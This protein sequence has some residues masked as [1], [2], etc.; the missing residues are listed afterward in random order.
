MKRLTKSA[1]LVV[2]E[3][4]QET[5][6]LNTKTGFIHV[7]NPTGTVVWKLL[8]EIDT[9]EAIIAA[10]TGLYDQSDVSE[11]EADVSG[12]ISDMISQ[13]ILSEN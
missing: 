11:I 2:R 8:D 7:L 5:V 1:D 10:M 13:G 3:V 9:P 6:I 12:I 4:D